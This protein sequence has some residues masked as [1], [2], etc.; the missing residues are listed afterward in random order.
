MNP[1]ATVDLGGQVALVTG[2]T[3]GVGRGIAEAF[4][5]AGA[6][7]AICG[8]NPPEQEI[9]V[10]RRKARYYPTDVR[11]ADAVAQ[12]V[13]AVVARM[14]SLDLLV[15]NAGGSPPADSATASP[16]FFASIVTLNLIAPF[17]V[18]QRANAVMQEQSTGGVII[19][20]GSV[21]ALR[22]SPGTAA[23]GAAKAG[24]LNLTRTL[25][26]EWAPKVRVNCVSAGPIR[27]ELSHLHYGDEAGI[28]AVGETIP[29]R[30][31]AEPADVADACLFFA[32]PL[33]AYVTGSDLLLHGGG[34]RPAFLDASNAENPE[35]GA[36]H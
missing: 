25:A 29:M 35:P 33:A 7:V 21:S 6:Q 26:V 28:A 17:F 5:R 8:R 14:G 16:R 23:Y 2:G 27:T 10:G 30:R 12:L 13:D 22:P 19:N 31:M 36:R 24:L 11:D 34:E 18:A 20:V 3:R 9:S 1:G 4:L 15:N 32:S